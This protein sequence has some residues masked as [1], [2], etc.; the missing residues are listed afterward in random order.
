MNKKLKKIL[1]IS[2]M[3]TV[4]STV[5]SANHLSLF[6]MTAY[7]ADSDIYLRS[8]TVD[9][10]SIDLSKSKTS[11]SVDVTKSTDEVSVKVA[12]E[13]QDDVVTID[14]D[15]VDDFDE[16]SSKRYKATA[17]LDEGNNTFKIKVTDKDGDNER[18]YTL[19]IDRG[20][21]SPEDDIYL[22][23]I[24]LSEGNISFSPDKTSY[25][26]NVVSSVSKLIVQAK[27]E[28]EDYTV[29]IDGDE[30]DE[31]DNYKRTISLANGE[32][33]I[34]IIVTDDEDNEREYT[35][36]INR[37]G[38]TSSTV[39]GKIDDKQDPIYLDDISINDEYIKNFNEQVTSYELNVKE[40]VDNI[41][42]KAP[43]E[44]DD[45]V[46]RINGDRGDSKNRKR[47]NLDQGKNIIEIR[48]SNEDTY[49]DDNYEE[50]TYKLIVY[51]GTSEGSATTI[52]SSNTNVTAKTSQW[53]INNGKWQYND[54]LGNPLKNM[55]FHDKST[56]YWYYLDAN[57][58][59]KTGWFQDGSG[60]WYYLYQS[61]AMAYNTMIDG[62]RLGANGAWV[63]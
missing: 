58:D 53:I 1:A 42:V 21:K 38:A 60:N 5:V 37:G 61:G 39:T 29:E 43:P 3:T 59:M 44:D 50:R 10:E 41:I 28:D 16:Y 45:N 32:N 11:Y 25:D 23:K 18:T 36:K 27:P 2:F 57:G 51:R 63:R 34:S 40:D 22:E 17:N 15:S 33:E 62:Y 26:I 14:G 8:L 6:T 47:V 55:W 9:G 35:L 20:G 13:D 54:A 30:V 52:P 49:D 56:G 24:S 4:F 31:D 7:A 48:V 12:T 46:V 19:K